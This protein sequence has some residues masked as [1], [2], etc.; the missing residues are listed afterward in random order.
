MLTVTC[1]SVVLFHLNMVSYCFLM[2]ADQFMP[3]YEL[4]PTQTETIHV[5]VSVCEYLSLISLPPLSSY[6]G[7]IN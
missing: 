5:Y 4:M 6:T 2:V 3:I 7:L 1:L